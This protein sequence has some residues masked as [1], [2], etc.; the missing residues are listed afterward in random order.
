MNRR[1]LFI[2]IILTAGFLGGGV[3]MH[4]RKVKTSYKVEKPR[5][6]VT[7]PVKISEGVEI[8]SEN[9]DKVFPGLEWNEL[10]KNVGFSGY[11]KEV[12]SN[13]ESFIVTNGSPWELTGFRVNIEYQDLK[14]RMLHS[15][16]LTV[17]CDTPSGESRK[18]DISAWDTQHT[19]YYYLGNEPKK[20]ATPFKVVFHPEA[21]WVKIE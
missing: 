7:R 13:Q 17:P 3:L 14:G 19:Y 11:D 6:E 2:A 21:F 1:I 9:S 10:L 8:T 18:L 4:G 12:N 15:R 20:V 16:L 5:K